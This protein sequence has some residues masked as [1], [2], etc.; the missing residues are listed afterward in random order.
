MDLQA[1]KNMLAWGYGTG[2][3]IGVMA[4][5]SKRSQS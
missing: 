2:D 4:S 3:D 5:R 1:R